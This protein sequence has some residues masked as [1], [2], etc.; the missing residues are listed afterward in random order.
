MDSSLGRLSLLWIAVVIAAGCTKQVQPVTG[1]DAAERKWSPG[2]PA[3]YARAFPEQDSRAAC[4]KAIEAETT[5]RPSRLDVHRF[6][7]YATEI[8]G[9]GNRTVI[10]EFIAENSAGSEV[11]YRALCVIQPGGHLDMNM[12]ETTAR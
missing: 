3:A 7:G 2:V 6:S 8:D 11:A 12:A 5:H 9:A 4:E 10:Q 1:Q